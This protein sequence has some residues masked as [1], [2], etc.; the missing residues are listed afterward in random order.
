VGLASGDSWSFS[1]AAINAIGTGFADAS[2]AVTVL[3]GISEINDAS[4]A[5]VGAVSSDGTAVWVANRA[6]GIDGTGSVSKIDIA[7]GAVAEI[8]DPSFN[9]PYSIS[10]DGTDVWVANRAGG[11]DG[12]GS[13]SK[14]SIATGIVTEI[15]SASFNYPAALSSDGTSVWVAN[16]AGGTNNTGAVSKIDIATGVVTEVDDASFNNPNAVSS[17]STNVWVTNAGGGSNGAGSVSKID[18]ATGAVTE[19]ND[20]SFNNPNAVSS[21]GTNVW[22]ANSAGGLDGA[23]SVS[24]IDSTTNAVTEINDPSF[25]NPNAVSSDGTDVWLINQI[26]GPS[27]QGSVSKIDIATGL[28]TE[29]DSAS[30]STL[31]D[32][33]SDGTDAWITSVY[34]GPASASAVIK[35]PVNVPS[36][37]AHVVIFNANGGLGFMSNETS[38][39]DAPLSGSSFF[40]FSGAFVGWNTTADG[41]GTSYSP[42]ATYPFTASVTLYAQWAVNPTITFDSNG[43]AG[44]MAVEGIS[45]NSP[46]QLTYNTLTNTGYGFTSWNTA[47][48]GSG[49]SYAD[50]ASITTSVSVTLYAQWGATVTLTFNNGGG[51]GSIS[52]ITGLVG[53]V[54]VLPTG[55]SLSNAGQLLWSWGGPYPGAAPGSDYTLTSSENLTADWAPGSW[56]N[57]ILNPNGAT[58]WSTGD[59]NSA[60]TY[61]LPDQGATSGWWTNTPGTLLGWNTAADGSGIEYTPDA[62]FSWTNITL[63]AQWN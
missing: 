59:P 36:K 3:A 33:S 52:P 27:G 44:S 39:I 40:N 25:N 45:Y 35:I 63:Y 23:G 19:I 26:G 4:F 57:V 54:V 21:D 11:L 5:A 30:F 37:T 14:I 62:A 56:V 24:K 31:S 1:V 34:G 12:T 22:V 17:D 41:S 43:G 48:D 55:A 42:G 8:V 20:S 38:T 18:I 13:V 49:T 7:T 28:V 2:N 50:G 15:N 9:T 47:P 61:A 60:G 16:S 29:I 32:I 6:G 46:S 10:S 58:G 51:T 53:T